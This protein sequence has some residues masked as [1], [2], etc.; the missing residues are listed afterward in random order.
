MYSVSLNDKGL[1]FK[2]IEQKI[3]K[4][5]CD[6]ACNM[7]REFLENLDEKLLN[8]RDTKIY[9]SKGLKK[10]ELKLAVSYIG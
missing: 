6:E 4:Y 8:E 2:E 5:A 3:Y 7:M 9:R 10:K 1:T